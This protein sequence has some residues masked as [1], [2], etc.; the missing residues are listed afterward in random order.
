M[1]LYPALPGSRVAG[2]APSAAPPAASGSGGFVRAA[3]SVGAVG[4][5]ASLQTLARTVAIRAGVPANVFEA[6]VEA[7]SAFDPGAVSSAGAMGL[8]QLMPGTARSLGVANPF[9]PV[10][11]L[12]GGARYLAEMLAQFQSVPLAL[13]AYNA[14]PGAVEFYHGIP[15][16]PQ[17]EAYVKR[18]MALAG[19]AS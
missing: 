7:E 14:G 12:E 18:V 11:N 13:A 4:D 10:Q 19:L 2:A 8:T 17:T 15:P 9:D 1:G 3:A 6:L 5:T 16:Y